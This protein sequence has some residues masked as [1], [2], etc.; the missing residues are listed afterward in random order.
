MIQ[1]SKKNII[2]MLFFFILIVSM[3]FGC[4]VKAEDNQSA[5]LFFN[6]LPA[7]IKEGE[8]VT[9]DV[10]INSQKQSVNAVS[11]ALSFP[12]SLLQ[13]VSISKEKSII[14]LWTEEPRLISNK[15]LFEGII[16]NPGFQGSNGVIFHIIFEAKKSGSVSI[17]FNEGSILANDGLGTN[18]IGSLGSSNFKIIPSPTYFSDKPLVKTSPTSKVAILPVITKYST[19]VEPKES[20][21]IVGKGEPLALTKIAFNNLSVKSLGEKLVNYLQSKKNTLGDVV[22]KNDE[23][24]IFQYVSN[25]DLVAGAYNA[26]PFLVNTDK[27]IEV[28]GPSVKLLINDSNIVKN[29][30]VILNIMGLFVPIVSLAVIIY[31]IPWFSWRKMRLIKGKMLLEE[32]KTELTAEELRKKSIN[33]NS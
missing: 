21:K 11:G 8:R 28:P 18:V 26:T 29:L 19:V 12:T 17:N 13:V 10:K 16:L 22:L 6:T 15:I 4:T 23:N 9:V 1:D 20:I 2:K 3:L 31:F 14:N 30:I 27:N 7:Q 33:Q 25:Q 5:F 24:G 32:E